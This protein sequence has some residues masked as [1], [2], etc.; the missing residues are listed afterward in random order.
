MLA[1][2]AVLIGLGVWQLQRLQ[3][4][5]GLIARDRDAHQGRA[6]HPRA[7]DRQGPRGARSELLPGPRRGPLSPRQGALS[8]CRVGGQGGL[9]CHH[10]ARDGRRRDGAG[11]SRLRARRAEGPGRARARAGRATWSPSPA[12]C[13]CPRPKALFTPDN[14]P[15]PIAG[16]GAT[17]RPWRARSFPG[18]VIQVAP[19]FLEAEKSRRPRRLARGRPDAAR[20]PQQPSAICPHLVSARRRAADRLRPLC[21]EPVP[22]PPLASSRSCCGRPRRPL[23]SPRENPHFLP[24]EACREICLNAR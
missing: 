3:W 8:L 17:C 24:A 5:E 19:F 4:K 2:F 22:R 7:G 12:S 11:R 16:S 13:G 23:G 14:E 10:P 20:N 18:G 15:A 6:H 9:A 21:A 1:A